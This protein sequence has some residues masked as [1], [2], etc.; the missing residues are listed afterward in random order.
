[1]RILVVEDEPDMARLIAARLAAAGMLCDTVGSCAEAEAAVAVAPFALAL[2]DR[3]LP[4]GDG[5][6]L[7][8]RLRRVRPGLPVI[9]VTA[10]DAVAHRVQGLDAGADDYLTKP[11]AGDELLA[12]IRAA[13]RRAGGEAA[14]PIN[15]GRLRFEPEHRSASVGGQPLHLRRRELAVLEALMLRTGRVVP[16]ERLV[17]VAFGLDDDVSPATVESHIS[18]LRRRLADLDAGVCIHPVRGVGYVLTAE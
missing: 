3:R 11:F 5:A 6:D 7:V 2:V 4:D 8:R 14:P 9:L 17:D 13:L 12:R 15:C 16:R 18:R 1:M 10:L